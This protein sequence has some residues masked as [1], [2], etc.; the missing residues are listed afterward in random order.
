[1]DL[2]S[3]YEASDALE[4]KME[5]EVRKDEV[6]LAIDGFAGSNTFSLS[7]AGYYWQTLANEDER[8]TA[9]CGTQQNLHEHCRK[10]RALG[11]MG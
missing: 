9:E 10:L 6:L 7:S 8:W 5:R 3:V 2:S 11:D 4:D 1:M